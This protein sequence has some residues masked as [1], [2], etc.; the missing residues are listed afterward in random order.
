MFII[1]YNIMRI[2]KNFYIIIEDI[3]I[4]VKY[5]RKGIGF[6]NSIFEVVVIKL[7]IKLFCKFVCVKIK[8]RY[9]KWY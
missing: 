5:M 6:I 3:L 9:E 1:N 8:V 7:V 4:V 2:S